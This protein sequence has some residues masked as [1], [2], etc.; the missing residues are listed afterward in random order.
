MP[1]SAKPATTVALAAGPTRRAVPRRQVGDRQDDQHG[2]HRR[3]GAH[4]DRVQHGFAQTG[5]VQRGG[6]AGALTAGTDDHPLQQRRNR[7]DQSEHEEPTDDRRRR[8]APATQLDLEAPAR[9]TGRHRGVPPH[10]PLFGDHDDQRH[11]REEQR[12]RE[13]GGLIGELVG[14]DRPRHGVVPQELDRSEV[15]DGV[16]EDQQG[17][18]R[19]GRADLRHDD[20]HEHGA[21]RA[22]QQPG[23]LLDRAGQVAQAGRHRKVDVGIGEQRQHEPGPAEPRQLRQR[24]PGRSDQ[25]VEEAARGEPADQ[26]RCADERGEHKRKRRQDGEEPPAVHVGASDQPGQPRADRGRRDG[27]RAG[28]PQ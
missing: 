23:T 7:S 8:H 18:G 12:E 25:V 21:G 9:R 24:D 22:T 13:G 1:G 28:Q 16:E 3:G 19:D 14:E 17:A 20:R 10:E 27:D 15:A 11:Q 2:E 4:R 6:T 5:T 26:R